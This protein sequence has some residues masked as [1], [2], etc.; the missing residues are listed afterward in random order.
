MHINYVLWEYFINFLETLLFFIF[1]HT[2]LHIRKNYKH[3]YLKQI[4]FLALHFFVLCTLNYFDLSSTLTIFISCVLDIGFSLLFY[5]DIFVVRIFWGSM[6]SIICLISEYITVSVPQTFF[7]V[8]SLELLS[9]G[10]LRMPFTLLYIALIAVLVFLFRCISNKEIQLTII[11]KFSY[12]LIS[13]AG[14]LIG[15][16]IML[17]TLESEEH[18][19]N[20]DFTFKMVLVNLVFLILFL[21]LLL[22]I[23]QLG[24]SKAVNAALLEQQKIFELEEMEYKTLLHTTEA[25]REMKHDIN[26]HLDVIQSLSASGQLDELQSY[27]DSYHQSLAHTH[28]LLSTGN[29]A[30]DCILS[31]KINSAQKLNIK[32]DFSVLVPSDFPLD[33]LSLSSL[34]GNMWNN[35]LEACQRLQNTQPHITPYIHFYIKPF[36]HMIIIHMENNYDKVIQQNGNYLS[37]KKGTSHGIGLKR[38]ANIIAGLK[39][40]FQINSENHV[41]TIHI[42]IPQKETTNEADNCNS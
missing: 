17:L 14:I 27:I 23:Y 20:P 12:L 35:A 37:M 21:F 15:H 34:L 3:I 25:L 4:V 33:A 16:Y 30:I 40:I 36:Q 41:F 31:N 42:M 38:M 29:T 26:I 11:Q 13:L 32:T 5:D 8:T 1:I 7:K 10:A 22:Y 39:G 2:K 19:H 24:Y 18:F 6:Y 28:Q 9:G